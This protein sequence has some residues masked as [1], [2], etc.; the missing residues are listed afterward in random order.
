ME[1]RVPYLA[2]DEEERVQKEM[3]DVA[4][5]LELT[6]LE[7]LPPDYFG[8]EWRKTMRHLVALAR[9]GIAKTVDSGSTKISAS[10]CGF[11]IADVL[12]EARV[13]FVCLEME[14]RGGKKDEPG[15]G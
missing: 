12:E 13:C 9:A 14:L 6:K 4:L 7:T 10:A 1:D 11:T 2:S 3:D 8:K 5:H 15:E